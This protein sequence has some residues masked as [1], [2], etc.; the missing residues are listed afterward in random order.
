MFELG[1]SISYRGRLHVIVGV[2]PMGATPCLVGLEDAKSGRVRSV[3][4]DD[5][6][7]IR[8]R[9]GSLPTDDHSPEPEL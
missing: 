5:P 1:K 2:T 4:Y 7:L 8:D 6:E 3:Q 9:E